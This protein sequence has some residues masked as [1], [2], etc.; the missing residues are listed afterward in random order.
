MTHGYDG[1]LGHAAMFIS[2]EQTRQPLHWFDGTPKRH[3][4]ILV[5]FTYNNPP[6]ENAATSRE[7]G[8]AVADLFDWYSVIEDNL[9]TGEVMWEHEC[10]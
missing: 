1:E 7:R 3:D 4:R 8:I 9:K 2:G 6:E 5:M 10:A